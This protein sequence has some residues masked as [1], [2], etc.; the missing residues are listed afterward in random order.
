LN[1][2]EIIKIN[3]KSRFPHYAKSL[4]PGKTNPEKQLVTTGLLIHRK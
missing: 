1:F 2:A 4:M 3:W